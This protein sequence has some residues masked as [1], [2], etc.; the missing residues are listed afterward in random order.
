MLHRSRAA[1]HRADG[2]LVQALAELNQAVH[3]TPMRLGLFDPTSIRTKDHPELARVY[4]DLGSPDSAI[5]VYER[6]LGVRSLSRMSIDAFESGE[7]LEQLTYLYA[8]RGENLRATEHYRRLANL[9]RDADP[10]LAPRLHA[11]RVRA[12]P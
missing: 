11:A 3:I 7:A 12:T 8:Q 9:W 6:Y 10:A 1:L 4:A 5:A 2:N